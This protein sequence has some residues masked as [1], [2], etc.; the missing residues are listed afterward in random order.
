MVSVSLHFLDLLLCGQVTCLTCLNALP[1]ATTLNI[2]L[3]QLQTNVTESIFC[4]PILIGIN[5]IT[6]L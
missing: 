6:F 3:M 1:L 2:F 4:K 5:Y